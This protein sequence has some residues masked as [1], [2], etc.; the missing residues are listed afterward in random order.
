MAV[1]PLKQR[2]RITK[3]GGLDEWGNPI[4]DE[5]LEYKCRVD[6][7]S[8]LVRD[9]TGKEVVSSA[10]I[11][12]EKLVDVGYDDTVEFTNE[13]GQTIRRTPLNISVIRDFTGKPWFTE[14]RL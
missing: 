5:T 8:E 12:I 7:K 6:E 3:P 9:R 13:L 10:R 1:I 2:V 14:V 4:P 11:L